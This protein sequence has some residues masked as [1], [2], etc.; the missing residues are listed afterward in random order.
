MSAGLF[1]DGIVKVYAIKGALVGGVR[2]ETPE[3]LLTAWYGEIGVGVTEWNTRDADAR[4]PEGKIRM[5]QNKKVKSGHL[6]I[7][8]DGQQ[9][10][11]GR[12]Y[13][14][15]L[16]SYSRDIGGNSGLPITDITLEACVKTYVLPEG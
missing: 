1:D 12:V 9:H 4:K 14:G 8:A 2:K 3:L 10:L 16:G 7:F 13:H 5:W 6:L 15:N 11:A